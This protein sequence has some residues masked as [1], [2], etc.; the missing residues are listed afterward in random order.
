MQLHILNMLCLCSGNTTFAKVVHS[1][2]SEK[3]GDA[4]GGIRRSDKLDLCKTGVVI[5]HNLD[6]LD[7]AMRTATPRTSY[8]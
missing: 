7:P 2:I 8:Q 1:N 4:W 5:N 6:Q 3:S